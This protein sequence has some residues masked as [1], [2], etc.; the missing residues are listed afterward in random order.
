MIFSWV[1]F[2]DP[3]LMEGEKVCNDLKHLLLGMLNFDS[4]Y[5]FKKHVGL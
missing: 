5:T 3:I 4:A 1:A 2:C